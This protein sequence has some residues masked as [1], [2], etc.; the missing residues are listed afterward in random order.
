MLG[1]A[2]RRARGRRAGPGVEHVRLARVRREVAIAPLGLANLL[3]GMETVCRLAHS[4]APSPTRGGVGR[5]TAQVPKRRS[6]V[7]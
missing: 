2:Q 6:R 1:E 3:A 5:M 4:V 7:V